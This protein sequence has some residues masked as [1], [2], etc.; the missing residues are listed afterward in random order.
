MKERDAGQAKKDRAENACVK[1]F[2]DWYTLISGT[3]YSVERTEHVF[4]ELADSTRWDFTATPRGEREWC[5]LEVK[6]LIRP[7]AKVELVHWIK[8][9]AA[10]TKQLSGL[11]QGEYLVVGTPSLWLNRNENRKLREILPRVVLTKAKNMNKGAS[12][13][14]GADILAKFPNWPSRPN[15]EMRPQPHLVKIPHEIELFKIS[16]RG[17]SIEPGMSPVDI[18]D[19]SGAVTEA[20]NALFDPAKEGILKA[21]EQLGLARVKGANMTILLLDCHLPWDPDNV[22]QIL[23]SKDHSYMSNIGEIFLLQVSEQRVS[24]VWWS[25]S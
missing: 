21:N 12:V 3:V 19:V 4:P 23:D 1:C 10:V 17:L 5:A 16:D 20:T 13:K 8:M 11:L 15:V 2:F 24:K 14:L 9:F 7:K 22:K 18:F 6:G 25:T